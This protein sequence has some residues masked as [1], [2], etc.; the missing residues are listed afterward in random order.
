MVK[1]LGRQNLAQYLL[2]HHQK[3]P[4]ERAAQG[5]VGVS[6]LGVFKLRPDLL[7]KI[8]SNTAGLHERASGG[9]FPS[10]IPWNKSVIEGNWVLTSCAFQPKGS[11]LSRTRNIVKINWMPNVEI[12]TISLYSMVFVVQMFIFKGISYLHSSYSCLHHLARS[13]PLLTSF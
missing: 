10:E 11:L 8:L 1:I 4:A 7:L 2:S 6:F 9:P 3:N 13:L 12:W 5:A